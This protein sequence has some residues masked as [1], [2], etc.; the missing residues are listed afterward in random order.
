MPAHLASK[1]RAT[2]TIIY[3]LHIKKRKKVSGILV[4]LLHRD[5][6]IVLAFVLTDRLITIFKELERMPT[7]PPFQSHSPQALRISCSISPSLITQP[8][9][10]PG[11]PTLKISPNTLNFTSKEYNCLVEEK[12]EA[13]RNNVALQKRLDEVMEMQ[14]VMSKRLAEVQVDLDLAVEEVCI[15]E[16]GR[17]ALD[18]GF[19]KLY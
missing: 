4:L 6:N 13:L 11:D 18:S 14:E 2:V 19:L 17:Q 10:P 12:E 3:P 8:S 15:H 5:I 7:P 1:A 16:K 9:S